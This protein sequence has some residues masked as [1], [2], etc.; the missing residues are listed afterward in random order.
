MKIINKN[1]EIAN[2]VIKFLKYQPCYILRLTHDKKQ[3]ISGDIDI[4]V[5]NND[6]KSFLHALK[7]N[8]SNVGLI[9]SVRSSLSGLNIY[10]TNYDFSG[11]CKLDIHFNEQYKNIN[12]ITQNQLTANSYID[13]NGLRYISL[14]N[15]YWLKYCF[16]TLNKDFSNPK[17]IIA[18]K[19]L[20]NKHP[21]LVKNDPDFLRYEN[22]SFNFFRIVLY[23]RLFLKNF[24]Q[25][26]IFF[27]I[28]LNYF[29]YSLKKIFFPKQ[30]LI[31]DGILSAEAKKMINLY[32]RGL[33]IS[34]TKLGSKDSLFIKSIG[35][36]SLNS[37]ELN[38]ECTNL[39][40]NFFK[41]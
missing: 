3:V 14:K 12:L 10:I 8:F 11:F 15:Q 6:R 16:Y 25:P 27:L 21:E 28:N 19:F 18:A 33:D 32:F 40:K 36:D 29:I 20:K 37:K 9:H 35:K 23:S 30:V 4:F 2:F 24:S 26:Y 31:F 34:F 38:I 41:N 17:F 1:K 22:K 5:K 7:S 39:V 13:K